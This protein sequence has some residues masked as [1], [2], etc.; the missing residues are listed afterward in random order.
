MTFEHQISEG[1]YHT[2]GLRQKNSIA[3]IV[4]NCQNCQN[5]HYALI[6]GPLRRETIVSRD[7]FRPRG[8]RQKLVLY[9]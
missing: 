8:A 7:R 5:G 3:F 4:Q 6:G 9:Y 2:S 1:T